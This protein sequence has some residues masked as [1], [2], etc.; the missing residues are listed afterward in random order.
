MLDTEARDR[1]RNDALTFL[2]GEGL[3]SLVLQ[4]P[5]AQTFVVIAHPAF[6]RRVPAAG[7]IGQL[8]AQRRRV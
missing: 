2:D 5:H 3:E 4:M 1:L 7:R 8:G 6:E